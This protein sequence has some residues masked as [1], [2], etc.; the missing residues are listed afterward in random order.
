MAAQN[1]S[2][3]RVLASGA[4]YAAVG[5][6]G[7]LPWS[8]ARAQSFP[9]RPIRLYVGYSAGGATDQVARL[10]A[11]QISGPLG[12][13]V[14]VMNMP[15][16]TGS[17]AAEHV[18]H[19]P[20]DGYTLLMISAADTA[21]PALRA[22][23]SY[24]LER[25]LVGVAPAMEGPLVL[26]VNPKVKAKS[27][28]EL[29]KLANSQP[30]QLTFGSPGVGNSLHLA[31]AQFQS[32]TG[33]NA[34]HVPY[35]GAAETITATLSGQVNFC[36]LMLSNALPLIKAGRLRPLAVTTLRRVDALHDVPTLDES[37][38]KGYSRSAWFGVAAPT[39]TP[40]NVLNKLNATIGKA[41]ASE[42]ARKV[43][44]QQNFSPLTGTPQQFTDLI[45]R[46][47][48]QSAKLI[49]NLG[50]KVE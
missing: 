46:E 41:I 28:A 27:V 23:L 17:I 35:K 30:G 34:L 47:V 13:Q 14:I 25:D 15:G 48:Q 45:R 38:L 4:A 37:G 11:H 33:I 32:M 26:V 5:L 21:V 12:Q 7:A 36:F 49:S 10:I 9:N 19:S 50:I 40:A 44:A 39:G 20:A 31:A 6:L 22:K 42:E 24:N 18:A 29:V 43:M 1:P 3:R 8:R 2:R 16:A